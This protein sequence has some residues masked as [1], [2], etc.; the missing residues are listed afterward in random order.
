VLDAHEVGAIGAVGHVARRHELVAARGDARA[1]D[2]AEDHRLTQAHVEV[3]AVARADHARDAALQRDLCVARRDHAHV[4]RG[5]LEPR[6]GA[7]PSVGVGPKPEWKWPLDETRHHGLAAEIDRAIAGPRGGAAARVRDAVAFDHHRRVRL[8]GPLP[9]IR[10]A[11]WR[12]HARRLGHRPAPPRMNRSSIECG[13]PPAR[14]GD[15]AQDVPCVARARGAVLD[16]L[17]G[18]RSDQQRVMRTGA[19]RQLATDRIAELPDGLHV[20]LCGA[21][22]PMPST[23]RSGPCVAVVAGR[24]LFVVDAGTNG[25]RNLQG[26]IGWPPGRIA[27]VFLTHYHSDHIDGLGE[28]GLLRWSVVAIASRC[29][30]WPEG[31]LDVAEGFDRAYRHD[32]GYRVA[33]HG[34]DVLP[35]EGAGFAAHPFATP[36]LGESLVLWDRDGIRISTF[37][38]QHEPV[39]PAVG[40]RFDYGGR[41]WSSRA[42]RRSRTACSRRRAASI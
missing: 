27:A 14:G 18:V 2:D 36:A 10:L 21:G 38:V 11:F 39:T 4:R 9:S 1:L 8:G 29:R 42:T 19:E 17:R 22:G 37:R 41:R 35:P 31:L 13:A 28:M 23:S 30:S 25:A 33:H 6:I 16:R 7:A 20:A 24:T 34:A 15:H 12:H 26:L 40:Y 3:V 5:C 32:V